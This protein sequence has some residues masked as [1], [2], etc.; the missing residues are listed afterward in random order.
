MERGARESTRDDTLRL[1]IAERD[2]RVKRICN[3][4]AA[5]VWDYE[6][7]QRQMERGRPRPQQATTFARCNDFAQRGSSLCSVLEHSTLL[8]VKTPALR[9]CFT[10]LSHDVRCDENHQFALGAILVLSLKQFS[11][12]R[13]VGDER[14]LPNF[15]LR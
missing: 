13:D 7:V 1:T 2:F 5:G 12:Q 14:N 10:N 6:F 11:D 8:R 9:R 15:R 3:C 4:G